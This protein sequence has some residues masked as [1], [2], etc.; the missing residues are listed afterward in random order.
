LS[1]TAYIRRHAGKTESQLV[2]EQTRGLDVRF[3]C[4]IPDVSEVPGAYKNAATVRRQIAQY[5]L[6]EIVDEIVPLGCIMAGEWQRN[7]PW[8]RGRRTASPTSDDG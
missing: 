1:R 7:A 5:G 6:A 8:R 2:A 4:G 3:F